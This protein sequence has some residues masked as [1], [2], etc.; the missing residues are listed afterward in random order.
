MVEV[1]PGALAGG[2]HVGALVVTLAAGHQVGRA[3][4]V[5]VLTRVTLTLQDE[6]VSV[7]PGVVRYSTTHR[8]PPSLLPAVYR[9]TVV[10]AEGVAAAVVVLGHPAALQLVDRVT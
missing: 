5:V 10:G 1:L 2:S 4:T 3:V 7:V 6:S 8:Y 9:L